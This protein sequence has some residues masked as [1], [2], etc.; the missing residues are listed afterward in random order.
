MLLY[1]NIEGPLSANAG[2][3]TFLSCYSYGAAERPSL[4]EGCVSPLIP[5]TAAMPLMVAEPEVIVE[6][7]V[8]EEGWHF[9]Q[10]EVQVKEFVR[11][12]KA[13]FE[14]LNSKNLCIAC[15]C[16]CNRY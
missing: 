1:N 11:S 12:L 5:A 2:E 3:E 14:S 10:S 4:I 13:N 16:L 7:K 15:W 6:Q 8:V 9:L